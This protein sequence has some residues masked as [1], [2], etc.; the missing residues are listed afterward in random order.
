MAAKP[1]LIKTSNLSKMDIR[2]VDFVTQFEK[3]WDALVEILGVMRPIKKDPGTA[4][5][6]YRVKMGALQ[7]G[8]EVG[9]GEDIPLT[10]ADFIPVKYGTLDIEKYAKA[11][12]IESVEKYG[13][14][15]AVDKTDEEFRN[16]LQ[17][18]VMTRFYDFA[19]TGELEITATNFQQAI[20]LSI[21]AVKYRFKKMH[22]NAKKVVL[23]VNTMDVYTY[24]G[25]ANISVQNQFGFEYMKNFMGA[26][27]VIL[28]AEVDPGT[29]IAIPADNIV[30]YY[31][32]PGDSDYADLG[33]NYTVSGETNLIGFAAQGNYSNATGEAYALM[34]F[35]MFA[36]FIDAIAVAT[37]ASTAPS[38][39]FKDPDAI[40]DEEDPEDPEAGE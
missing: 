30:L 18:E 35:T 24:L 22:R 9:E 33:L 10:K 15:L 4:L 36:E 16:E 20:A 31:T 28:T 34:G 37:F 1:N 19:K 26:D 32:D 25:E 23:F 17:D 39:N 5:T 6:S 11:V 13:A 12:S 2:K 38:F 7:G 8:K 29:V 27:T 40:E 14:R 21:G 3:N